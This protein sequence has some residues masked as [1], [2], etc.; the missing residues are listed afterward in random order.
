MDEISHNGVEGQFPP[1]LG[2]EITL[3]DSVR[4]IGFSMDFNAGQ[5]LLD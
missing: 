3:Y 5:F 4:Q 1:F 2:L